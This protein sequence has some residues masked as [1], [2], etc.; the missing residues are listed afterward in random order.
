[1]FF[2]FVNFVFL[3]KKPKSIFRPKPCRVPSEGWKFCAEICKI[4]LFSEIFEI[5]R[6]FGHFF[7][8]G[9]VHPEK[10]CF[11]LKI[12]K[13][14]NFWKR[15]GHIKST[16]QKN[17]NFGA[18]GGQNS[19]FFIFRKNRQKSKIFNVEIEKTPYEPD[20]PPSMFF[21]IF[22]VFFQFFAKSGKFQLFLKNRPKSSRRPSGGGKFSSFLRPFF[23][24]FHFFLF[25]LIFSWFLVIFSYMAPF[26]PKNS[27]FSCFLTFFGLFRRR[28]GT[29]EEFLVPLCSNLR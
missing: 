10:H 27:V 20:D 16:L 17:T 7:P 15:G 22:F 8:Y 28:G 9:A 5:F 4:W 3:G 13:N 18:C 24:F 11:L 2:I 26:I 21:I 19:P 29:I 12:V 14:C 1:M 23:D 6:I 25:F